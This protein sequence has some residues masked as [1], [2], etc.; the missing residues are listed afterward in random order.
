MAAVC[1]DL[2]RRSALLVAAAFSAACASVQPGDAG[3]SQIE[4]MATPA[5]A[6]SGTESLGVEWRAVQAPGVGTILLAVA[7]PTDEGPFP[8]VVILHGTHGFAREYV[9]LAKD[10]SRDGVVAVAACWFAPGSGAGT[11]FVSPMSCPSN[12]P[13]ISPH[14]S[15]Q[16]TRTIDVIMRAVRVLPGVKPDQ[17]ALFGHSRGGGAA[18]NYVLQGG[19]AQAVI[20]N[21]AGYPDEL[22]QQAAKFNAPV[23]ILHGEQDSPEDGGG[24][25]TDVRRA[26]A[27]QVALQD[28]GKPVDAVFYEAGRH[29]GLFASPSQ[30]ADEVQRMKAFLQQ[31][32]SR[33]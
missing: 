8:A 20:L 16:A 4:P 31:H 2:M 22:I 12:T 5:R 30:H 9:E 6:P 14:Q 33:N 19:D 1:R 3:T 23:L 27:F 25:I 17:V 15:Q 24:P 13:S 28:A 11:R 29:N 21:S 26:R 10:L 7:R 18:W 32:L